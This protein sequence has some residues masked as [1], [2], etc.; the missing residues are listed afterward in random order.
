MY[1]GMIEGFMAKLYIYVYNSIV[2]YSVLL[3]RHSFVAWLL[4]FYYYCCCFVVIVT[5]VI[6]IT[7]VITIATI[8]PIL[9]SL[10]SC[11]SKNGSNT[12]MV[13]F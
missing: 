10:L 8:I 1:D 5:V 7:I 3:H 2:E 9:L 11:Y 6:A 4:S 13:V 12:L